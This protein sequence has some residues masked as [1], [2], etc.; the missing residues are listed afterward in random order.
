MKIRHEGE[1]VIARLAKA[2][3]EIAQVRNAWPEW[4]DA[5]LL[6]ECVQ[7]ALKALERPTAALAPAPAGGKP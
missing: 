3:M 1:A 4:N 6:E 5:E 7:T 2:L